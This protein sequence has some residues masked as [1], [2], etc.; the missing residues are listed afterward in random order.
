MQF[1]SKMA[2]FKFEESDKDLIQPLAKYLDSHVDN[3]YKFF[4][5]NI[6]KEKL[7]IK[8]IPTKKEFDILYQKT[9][10]SSEKWAVGFYHN[11]EIIY[12]SL[13]NFQNTEHKAKYFVLNE[14]LKYY[15]KTI[16]HEYVLY[17]N[18]IFK[19]V[20]NCDYTEKYLSEGIATYLSG[21]HENEKIPFNFTCEDLL[22]RGDMYLGYYLVTKYFVENYDKSFVLN[23]FKSNKQ[24][25]EFLKNEIFDKAKEFYLSTE[26]EKQ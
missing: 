4:E 21:Q 19:K 11:N 2:I 15:K 14:A 9:W 22:T 12:L 10:G 17:V 26:R 24:S 6:P 18:D 23:I 1:E 5:V 20:N 8:I 13:H 16:V 3:I 25:R 7:V